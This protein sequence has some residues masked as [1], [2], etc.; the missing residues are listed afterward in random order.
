M[1]RRTPRLVVLICLA[2]LALSVQSTFS[3]GMPEGS[4]PFSALVVSDPRLRPS[5]LTE[6]LER[7][8]TGL[9]AEV[10]SGWTAFQASAPGW[11]AFVDRRTGRVE[12]AEGGGLAWISDTADLTGLEKRARAFLPRIA[13]LLGIEP[14]SLVL[15]PGRSG[16]L[17]DHLWTVD[18][19]VV[20]DGLPVEGARVVFRINHGN[21]VQI[22]TEN[23]PA[24]GTRVPPGRLSREQALAVVARHVGGFSAADL[25]VDGGSVHLL[26]IQASDHRRGLARVWQVAFER[27]GVLGTWRARVDAETGE[28][29]EFV[30][31]NRYGQINGGVYL[32]SPAG[33]EVVRPM[34]FADLMFEGSGGNASSSGLFPGS[35][36]ASTTLAG[37]YVKILDSCGPISAGTDWKGEI[38][39]GTSG[40]TNCVTPGSG[41][42]GNTHAA[43]TQFYHLNRAKEIGRSWLPGNAWLRTQL[44]ARVNLNSTCNA[45]WNGATVNFYRSGGGCGNTGEIAAIALHEYGHGLDDNDGNGSL[46]DLGTAETYG[47]WTAALV[48]HDSCMG[49]GFRSGNCGGYGDACTSCTGVR[50]IDWARHSSETPHTVSNFTHLLCPAYFG[51]EGPCG[52][53]G[54]CESYISSEAL[55]DFVNRDLPDPGSPAAWAV[56]ERLWY[57]S[58]A[59]ATTAFTCTTSA[60][61]WTSNGCGAGSLWR[62]LRAADDDDGDLTNGTPHS[63]HLF[64]AFDRHG[65]ACP[66]DAGANVCFRGCTPP[67]APVPT[68]TAGTAE[69]E[70]SWTGSELG[71]VHDVYR[72][73]TGCDAGLVRVLD[74]AAGSLFSDGSVVPGQTYF[75]RV[76][77]H[78][79]G[80]EACAAP[81]SSCAEA[82]PQA[83][84]CS[85]PDAPDELAAAA[86]GTSR[87]D[88]S[89]SPVSGA[90]GYNVYRSPQAG[91]PFVFRGTVTGTSF[92]DV[93]LEG[94]TAWFYAVRAFTGPCESALSVSVSATTQACVNVRLFSGDFESGAGLAG[95]STTRLSGEG[96]NS[97]KGIQTCSS[98]APGRLFRFGGAEC[99]EPYA[100]GQLSTA[101]PAAFPVP[102]AA[103]HVRLAF[104]HRWDFEEGYDGGAVAVALDDAA[105]WTYAGTGDIRTGAAPNRLSS[106]ACAPPSGSGLPIF[107]GQSSTVQSTVVDLDPLCDRATGG[108]DGCAG[109]TLRAGFVAVTDCFLERSGWFL[110]DVQVTACLPALDLASD[111]HTVTPCRLI[112]TRL[113]PGPL[114]GPAL[115][116]G[117]ARTFVL[118]GACGI[119]ATARALA[120]NLTVVQPTTAG[121]LQVAPGTLPGG[122]TSAITFQAGQIRSNNT[123]LTLDYDGAGTA[124]IFAGTAGAVHL[125]VDVT[126]YF[127]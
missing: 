61:P 42:A 125:V 18:F 99:S 113:P 75:Y 67:A 115:A 57:L 29:L 120:V 97:W 108:I 100:A 35:G 121:F 73:E 25:F 119:P 112:D 19:D 126:G 31:T 33:G 85:P 26:P 17:A 81:P 48:T 76:T 32:S 16:R 38:A 23:L 96:S 50:D 53:E 12:V 127:E 92:T 28:I 122:G 49:P 34:P 10:V 66:A 52:R 62:T 123:V 114:G 84:A 94:G 106:A 43:R 46:T 74:D 56:A 54:H 6:P 95:W 111:F 64:A 47:D 90:A 124:T 101:H 45:Y 9:A 68:A 22:G 116:P 27:R 30:D 72:S 36:P 3:Q 4:G 11:R 7:A 104:R 107:S 88:L 83:P 65:I 40:G 117:S 60:I 69:V 21:L 109:H 78:P 1:Y 2:C 59:T 98:V 105:A 91:G 63:C 39:L 110:D 89:W 51:Y 118:T 79:A 44:G 13:A 70:L 5:P 37:P 55:W 80:S 14:A 41:G 77:A 8:R 86:Q 93:R 103:G 82:T 58:R 20:R 15:H 102:A 87:I 24:P 71:V